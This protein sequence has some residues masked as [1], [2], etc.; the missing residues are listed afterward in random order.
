M[1]HTVPMPT[2]EEVVRRLL[3][4]VAERLVERAERGDELLQLLHPRLARTLALLE[5]LERGLLLAPLAAHRLEAVVPGLVALPHHVGKRV[6]LRHL[7]VGDL[8]LGLEEGEPAFDVAGA[9]ALLMFGRARARLRERGLRHRHGSDDRNGERG[10]GQRL[11]NGHLSLPFASGRRRSASPLSRRVRTGASR[12][13]RPGAIKLRSPGL[14]PSLVASAQGRLRLG[15]ETKEDRSCLLSSACGD[16]PKRRP[17]TRAAR[18]SP[19]LT[20]RTRWA[21]FRSARRDE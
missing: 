7:R 13:R 11:R 21:F 12:P 4:L 18:R 9:R 5:A 17:P 20:G 6:P 2:G 1:A 16:W 3:L 8:E 10:S 19:R 14:R 15:I